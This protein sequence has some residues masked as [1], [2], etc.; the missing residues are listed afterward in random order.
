LPPEIE[1]EK[2]TVKPVERTQRI[3]IFGATGSIGKAAI[4]VCRK[5]DVQVV[6]VGI[7]NNTE[8]LAQLIPGLNLK[9]IHISDKTIRKSGLNLPYSAKLFLGEEN[10]EDAIIESDA[11]TVLNGVSGGA[12]LRYSLATIR[13]K[14]KKLALANKETLVI[15]G[16]LFTKAVEESGTKVVPVDSEHS[17]LFR[18]FRGVDRNLVRRLLLTASGGPFLERETSEPTP[19]EALSHPVWQM[20]KRI[21]IDSATMFNK[22]F[23]VIEAH[24]L[25]RF[26]YDRIE[27]LIHPEGLFHSILELTDGAMVALMSVADM[28]LSIAYALAYPEEPRLNFPLRFESVKNCRFLPA[29]SEKFRALEALTHLRLGANNSYPIALNAADEVAVSAFLNRTI[30]FSSI[31]KIVLETASAFDRKEPNTIEDVYH[32]DKEARALAEERVKKW[33]FSCT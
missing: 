30:P 6:G 22:V 21:S 26:A 2:R 23:E 1:G 3:F 7:K 28:R 11:D 31:V 9:V 25:F 17:A 16:K 29:D 33:M 20:G 8:S 5:T 4:D 19:E 32:L 18:L 13:T 24:H 27:I 14:T 12:G 10:I 15:A